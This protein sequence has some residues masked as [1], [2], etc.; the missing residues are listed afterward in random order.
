MHM[1]QKYIDEYIT[2]MKKMTSRLVLKELYFRSDAPDLVGKNKQIMGISI[3][4]DK[5]CFLKELQ[6]LL[7]QFNK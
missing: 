5:F 3:G 1:K 7:L 2:C 4:E 6:I